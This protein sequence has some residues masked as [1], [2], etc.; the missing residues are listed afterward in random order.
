MSMPTRRFLLTALLT[1]SAL[2]LP[3]SARA[4]VSESPP[5]VQITAPADGDMVASP[6]DVTL[7]VYEGDFGLDRV[8]LRVD[9]S[10]VATLS[11]AP[12]TF[13][14]VAL[15]EGMHELVAVAIVPG[16][17][18]YPSPT[19]QVAVL[20]DGAA[21]DTAKGCAVTPASG[22]GGLALASLVLFGLVGVRRRA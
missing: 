21:D 13:T 2:A 20:D 22:L 9:G 6:L 5:S 11:E 14:G 19:V 1:V 10:T 17:D 4:D 15:G 8:E 12:W 3:S 18:E 7:Q 16:G